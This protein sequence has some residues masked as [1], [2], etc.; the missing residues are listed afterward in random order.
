MQKSVLIKIR[1]YCAYQERCHSEVRYKLIELGARGLE[2]EDYIVHL[3]AEDFLNEERF[4]QVYAGGKFRVLKWGKQ[5]IVHGLKQKQVSA[6]CIKKGLQ[7]I[8]D[9]D[10]E[11]TLTKLVEGKW[12]NLRKPML[13]LAVK[14]KILTYM[15]GK[16]YEQQLVRAAI[17]KLKK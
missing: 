13:S 9:D 11:T 1:R 4:A 14:Q 3:I 6:Y 5:K 17:A 16:G 10:Y 12:E 8:P 15:L 2:L 7:E